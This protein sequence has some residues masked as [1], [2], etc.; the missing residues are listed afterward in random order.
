MNIST[1]FI[2]EAVINTL[3]VIRSHGIEFEEAA[4]RE[5]ARLRILEAIHPIFSLRYIHSQSKLNQVLSGIRKGEVVS[6]FSL[7][8]IDA[9]VFSE[10]AKNHVRRIRTTRP[11]DWWQK[12]GVGRPKGGSK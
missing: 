7:W 10:L 5:V 9:E 11:D 12:N 3:S 6:S 2:E 1:D 4:A 8:G